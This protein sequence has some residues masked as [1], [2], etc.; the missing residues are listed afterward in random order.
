MI[1]GEQI[2]VPGSTANLGG[3]FDTL[4]LAVQLYLRVRIIEVREDGV[5]R[6]VLRV[7]H[8]VDPID[9]AILVDDSAAS[10]GVIPRVREGLAAFNAAMNTGTNQIALIALADRMRNAK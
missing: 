4:G 6:E 2:V 1:A 8:A 5:A 7:S 9:I 3:G 10:D